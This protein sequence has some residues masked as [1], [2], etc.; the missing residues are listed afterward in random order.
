M[1]KTVAKKE[2]EK[3]GR[4]KRK[5]RQKGM[6]DKGKKIGKRNSWRIWAKK[7]SHLGGEKQQGAPSFLCRSIKLLEVSEMSTR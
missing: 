4:N 7:S 3:K 6:E 5:E 1:K 2:G